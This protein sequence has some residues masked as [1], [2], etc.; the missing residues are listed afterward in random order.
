MTEPG[1]RA[2]ILAWR[3]AERLRLT[4]LRRALPARERRRHAERIAGDIADMLDGASG[5]VVSFYW[6]I[7]AEPNLLPLMRVLEEAGH[8]CVLPIVVARATPLKFRSW[9][10][11]EPLVP[12]VWNIPIP[13]GGE[14][15]TPDVT[16]APVIGFDRACYRLGYGG[17]FFDRTLASLSTR[18]RAIGVGYALAAIGTIHPLPH[19]IAM[20]VIVTERGVVAKPATDLGD[21]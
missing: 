1:S 18:P 21:G 20:D 4:A 8:R 6:P 15:L 14:E 13:A 17:G 3:K 16:I 19:D 12:G 5:R 9:R 10:D 7:R 11:G 2:E